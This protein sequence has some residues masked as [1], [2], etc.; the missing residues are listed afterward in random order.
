MRAAVEKVT[1]VPMRETAATSVGMQAGGTSR[2]Q[3]GNG[4]VVESGRGVPPRSDTAAR[5]PSGDPALPAFALTSRVLG[6]GIGD[7]AVKP[8]DQPGAG[9]FA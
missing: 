8:G 5:S 3:A 6:V 4:T 1:T 7:E 9:R 2:R